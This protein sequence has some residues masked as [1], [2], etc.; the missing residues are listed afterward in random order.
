MEI[1]IPLAERLNPAFFKGCLTFVRQSCCA[2]WIVYDKISTM[3]NFKVENEKEMKVFAE[4]LADRLKAGDIVALIGD[5][6]TG[7]TTFSKYVA[8]SL[9][10]KETITS[11]TFN[12]VKEYHSGRLPFYHFDVYRIMD[13][14][15]MFEI[16]YEEY[17]FGDGVSMVEWADMIEELLPEDTIFIH[18]NHLDNAESR[19][20]TLKAGILE[21]L[22]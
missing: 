19:G 9:G 4:K 3:K 7:K 1:K 21:D 5:L 6:G 2:F 13:P 22:F 12:I 14:G 17:F 15:E 18:I 8:A 16:G 11:P 20:V 10:V